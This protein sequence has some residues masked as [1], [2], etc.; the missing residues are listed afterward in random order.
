MKTFSD[1]G[2]KNKED[3]AEVVSEILNP[4]GEYDPNKD[5]NHDGVFNNADKVM[6]QN[7]RNGANVQPNLVMSYVRCQLSNPNAASYWI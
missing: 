5:V 7:Y 3:I 6:M 2:V 1:D 4:S